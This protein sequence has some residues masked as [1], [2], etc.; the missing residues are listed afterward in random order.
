MYH[1]IVP[2]YMLQMYRQDS[3][4]CELNVQLELE[5]I[6]CHSVTFSQRG[7]AIK[8]RLPFVCVYIQ[9]NQFDLSK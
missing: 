2:S 8:S 3:A 1:I 9:K 7:V 6:H 4:L 5:I